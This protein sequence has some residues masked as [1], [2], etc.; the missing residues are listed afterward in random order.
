[1]GSAAGLRP[2]PLGDLEGDADLQAVASQ[3]V[4]EQSFGALQ[5][6]EDRV[7]VGVQGPGG[8]CGTELLADV[9]AQGVA[10]FAVGVGE[11]AERPGDELAGALHVLEGE[12]DQ[13][14]IGEPRGCSWASPPT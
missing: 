1:M 9:R 12:R 11:L 3:P 14:D 2:E 5:A 13:L 4:R 8:A 10:Q 6:V 7:A